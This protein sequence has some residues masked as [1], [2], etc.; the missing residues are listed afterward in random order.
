MAIS[1]SAVLF[2]LPIWTIKW[3]RSRPLVQL[4]RRNSGL[5]RSTQPRFG[6]LCFHPSLSCTSFEY[7]LTSSMGYDKNE[8]SSCRCTPVH[9]NMACTVL[10]SLVPSFAVPSGFSYAP[11]PWYR[12]PSMIN[13]SPICISAS[14]TPLVPDFPKSGTSSPQR[15]LPGTILVAPF[16]LRVSHPGTN[17]PSKTSRPLR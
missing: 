14:T 7:V 15:W 12:L 2:L 9:E 1:D 8:I 10:L 11:P 13:A 6:S 17:K 4:V 5:L 16:A 3:K